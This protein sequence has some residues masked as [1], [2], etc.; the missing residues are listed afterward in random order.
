MS[1]SAR[2]MLNAR[3][4]Q[5]CNSLK[6]SLDFNAVKHILADTVNEFIDKNGIKDL[7]KNYG[8]WKLRAYELTGVT[9]ILITDVPE[10]MESVEDFFEEYA[11]N[12]LEKEEAEYRANHPEIE[13]PEKIDISGKWGPQIACELGLNVGPFYSASIKRRGVRKD[14]RTIDRAIPFTDFI[15]ELREY[16]TNESRWRLTILE[17]NHSDH[18]L[19][20]KI[21]R[22]IRN[23]ELWAFHMSIC[24]RLNY[25]PAEWLAFLSGCSSYPNGPL[26]DS[27]IPPETE[28]QEKEEPEK[29][30]EANEPSLLRTGRIFDKEAKVIADQLKKIAEAGQLAKEPKTSGVNQDQTDYRK[31]LR[32]LAGLDRFA[33]F[34]NICDPERL[35]RDI[36]NT[37]ATPETKNP[38]KK[39][40]E[41]LIEKLAYL[42]GE[43]GP[44]EKELGAELERS[45]QE[46]L[47]NELE[48]SLRHEFKW[49]KK[50]PEEPQPGSI[51]FASLIDDPKVPEGK[52][53]Q[54]S[55][56]RKSREVEEEKLRDE[57]FRSLLKT[58]R[59]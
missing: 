56:C 24:S 30:S 48:R 44:F 2:L 8:D 12:L 53:C 10:D 45:I 55:R 31:K 23:F 32:E 42:L 36:M 11:H 51:S 29:P 43:G 15:R 5:A 46:E 59:F 34:S 26:T 38:K 47:E 28:S 1:R 22:K 41:K 4:A 40:M 58:F 3:F 52:P 13:S 21:P 19:I 49:L 27:P 39:G 33:Q 9:T 54:C 20:T 18:L 17:H 7:K 35:A 50:R 25:I 57:Y 16:A 6:A 14:I 37:L